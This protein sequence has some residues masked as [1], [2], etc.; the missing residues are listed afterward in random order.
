MLQFPCCK[1]PTWSALHA[2]GRLVACLPGRGSSRPAV[3]LC[4]ILSCPGLTSQLSAV[5]GTAAVLLQASAD[6]LITLAAGLETIMVAEGELILVNEAGEEQPPPQAGAAPAAAGLADE[7]P[8]GVEGAPAAAGAGADA[9]DSGASLTADASGGLLA[10]DLSRLLALPW[11]R[12]GTWWL[13]GLG[14]QSATSGGL[15]T[16]D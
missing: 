16:A 11:Q 2:K 10:C 15:L 4:L 1:H 8:Q 7:S 5:Q 12:A 9:E 6:H 13:Q 14:G 3:D